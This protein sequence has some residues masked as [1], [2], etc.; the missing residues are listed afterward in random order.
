MLV[1]VRRWNGTHPGGNAPTCR[2]RFPSQADLEEPD[3]VV[4]SG[5]FGGHRAQVVVDLL[6]GVHGFG[7]TGVAF[8]QA[9]AESPGGVQVCFSFGGPG[10]PRLPQREGECLRR[11][12]DATRPRHFAR[13]RGVQPAGQG[14]G[15]GH[16]QID[17]R[18]VSGGARQLFAQHVR[19]GL[20]SAGTRRWFPIPGPPATARSKP[21]MGHVHRRTYGSQASMRR[22]LRSPR[23]PRA[24]PPLVFPS[25]A[26]AG[27]YPDD[28]STWRGFHPRQVVEGET[29]RATVGFE[30]VSP[31]G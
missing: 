23:P 29:T 15:G 10:Q 25:P 17:T 6:G 8:E 5:A 20:S 9:G 24:L 13:C 12:V 30:V 3:A 31:A 28:R 2:Q 7:G 19:S 4:S 27:S 16:R 18:T 11:R 21:V 14:A 1:C 26:W 22:A